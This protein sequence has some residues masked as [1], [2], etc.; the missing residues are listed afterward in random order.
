VPAALALRQ[1]SYDPTPTSSVEA[2]HAR[3]IDVVEWSVIV[4]LD[5]SVG[6]V[7]SELADGV[8]DASLDRAPPVPFAAIARTL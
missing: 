2:V 4:R 5:G 1:I 3:L 7:V 6:G 8:A